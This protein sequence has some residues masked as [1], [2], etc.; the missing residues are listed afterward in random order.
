MIKR[1]FNNASISK[2]RYNHSRYVSSFRKQ[3]ENK[4]YIRS[5]DNIPNEPLNYKE[6]TEL[7]KQLINPDKNDHKFLYNQISR[8]IV[9]GVD[10]TNKLK[11]NFLYDVA[12]KKIETPIISDE[13]AVKLLGTMQGG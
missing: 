3:I 1:I 11:A 10:D 8:R 13:K 7:C 5:K 9:P 6:V 12:T 2:I 4:E